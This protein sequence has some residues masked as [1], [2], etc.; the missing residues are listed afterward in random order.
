MR[1][2][3]LF[4]LISILFSNLTSALDLTLG[5]LLP[6]SSVIERV[7][8]LQK[9]SK[10]ISPY[11]YEMQLDGSTFPLEILLHEE[12]HEVIFH[13]LSSD[14]ELFCLNMT[15]WTDTE[16]ADLDNIN[17]SECY[18]TPKKIT[19]VGTFLLKLADHLA[20]SLGV[21]TSALL[22]AS[23]IRC[24]KSGTSTSLAFLHFTEDG[25]TWYET[26]GYRISTEDS[27]EKDWAENKRALY[28]FPI[29]HALQELQSRPESKD[30][31]LVKKM[32]LFL[33]SNAAGTFALF[34]QTLWKK[35]CSDYID[36][37]SFFTYYMHNGPPTSFSYYLHF[38]HKKSL[39][40]RVR[41]KKTYHRA[42]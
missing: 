16:K 24:E 40:M 34:M 3:I 22:D 13:L 19:G 21:H 15:I 10:K 7:K 42:Q 32:Q 5:T 38:F 20:L 30:S 33:Q 8:H 28:N 1:K 27:H 14:S 4:F 39:W 36:S 23:E 17:A 31:F 12:D 26:K 9:K 41:M 2:R 6:E 11:T 37:I 18:I 29:S 25:F 35:N